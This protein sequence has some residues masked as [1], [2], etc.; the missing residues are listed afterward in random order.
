MTRRLT[1]VLIASMVVLY[2]APANAACWTDGGD[3]DSAEPAG[4]SSTPDDDASATDDD[5]IDDDTIDDD[6]TDDDEVDDD[7]DDDAS[8][9]DSSDDDATDDDTDDD[10]GDDDSS[11]DDGDDDAYAGCEGDIYGSDDCA[12][13]MYELYCEFEYPVI[14]DDVLFSQGEAVRQCRLARDPRW[15]AI[16]DCATRA[17]P[18]PGEGTFCEFV[19]C[20]SNNGWTEQHLDIFDSGA[21]WHPV[22]GDP[23]TETVGAFNF[24]CLISDDP[25]HQ[26][27]YWQ[28]NGAIRRL[29][30]PELRAEIFSFGVVG[31]YPFAGIG[32]GDSTFIS[33]ALVSFWMSGWWIAEGS[34]GGSMEYFEGE[35]DLVKP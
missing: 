29:P 25:F 4:S 16:I 27:R 24:R 5:T 21:Y 15:Q 14:L 23:A 31:G 33:D 13:W 22:D 34:E 17:A 8:D 35:F 19:S 9:D 30:H 7:V 10:T 1:I 18:E 6:A 11:D 32:A 12:E 20:L 2:A 3:D 28:L 26:F